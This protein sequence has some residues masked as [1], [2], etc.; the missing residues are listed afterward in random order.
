[1]PDSWRRSRSLKRATTCPQQAAAVGTATMT[2][3][4]STQIGFGETDTGRVVT[5]ADPR[6]GRAVTYDTGNERAC[7]RYDRDLLEDIKR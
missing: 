7:I 1:M 3:E 4:G 2:N 6:D 5:T